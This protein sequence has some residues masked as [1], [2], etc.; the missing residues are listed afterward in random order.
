MRITAPSVTNTRPM[1]MTCLMG[2]G[3]HGDVEDRKAAVRP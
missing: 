1:V 3:Y 2:G